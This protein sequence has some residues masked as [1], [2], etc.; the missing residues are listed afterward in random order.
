MADFIRSVV[1]DAAVLGAAC[2]LPGAASLADLWRVLIEERNTVRDAPVGRWPVERF[3]HPDQDRDGF[4]YTFAGGY[5][6]DPFAF[7]PA[8]FGISPREA[9]QVDPQQRV[10]LEVVREAFDDAGIPASELAGRNVGVYVGAST[11]DYQTGTSLDLAAMQSHFMTGNSL[12]ILANRISYVFNLKGPSFTVDTA[13]SSSLV[14][15]TQ[16]MT[17]LESGSIDM[18][19]VAGVNLL[20]SPAPFI[21]FSRARM[22]SPTGRCRPFSADGDGYVRAEGAVAIILQRLD[23]RGTNPLRCVIQAAGTNSDGRTDGIAMP[24]VEGQRILLDSIYRQSG[25]DPEQ[26]AFIEAHGTGTAVGDPAEAM[27]I[28]KALG[29]HR[30]EPLPI[31]SVKSNIGHL[32]SASGLASFAKV[33]L[34]LEHRVLPRSLF[35]E[36]LNPNIDFDGLNLSAS[37]STRE[38]GAGS[39]PL[40]AGIC[41]YGFGGTNAHVILREASEAERI[42]QTTSGRPARLLLVS[43]ASAG[44]LR[45]FA[46][47]IA[48]TIQSAPGGAGAVAATLA[49]RRERMAHRLA[50]PIADD[51]QVLDALARF[52]GGLS[53]AEDL[54]GGLAPSEAPPLVFVYSGNGS[55]FAGMGRGAYAANTAFRRHFD[56]LD[57]LFSPIAGWS[58]R[59]ALVAVD[60]EERLAATSVSQPLIFAIQSALTA[61]LRA[62]DFEPIAVLGHSVGEVAAAEACGALSLGDAVLLIHHRS[63][64]QEAVRGQG[65]M[66]VVAQ[67]EAGVL[68]LLEDPR[69]VRIAV[70]AINSPTSTTV[71]GPTDDLKMLATTCRRRRIATVSLDIDYPF[72]TAALDGVRDGMRH[73]L[74]VIKPVRGATPFIST[75][76]GEVIAGDRLD[77]DHWWRNIRHPVRFAEAVRCAARAGGR[78]FVEIGARPILTGAMT[79]TLREASLPGE[80]VYSL[81]R[82]DTATLDP[83]LQLAA[84]LVARGARGNDEQL[85]GEATATPLPAYPWQHQDF[86]LPCTAE[87]FNIYGRMANG[88][89]RHPLIGA[90]LAD[91]SPEWRT[92]LDAA[93]VPYLADHV[94]DGEIVVPGTALIEMALAAGRDL[95]GTGAL[96]LDEFDIFKALTLPGDA[97]REISLRYLEG[98]SQIEIW[99]RPRFASEEWLLHARGWIGK[100]RGT[101]GAA[102]S[103]PIP[104]G[105]RHATQAEIYAEARRAALDYGPYFRLA[106]DC[107]YDAVTTD[108]ALAPPAGGLGAFRDLHVLHPASFDASFHGLLVS[109]PQ[110]DGETKVHL[111]VRFRSVRVWKQG[112][113]IRHA[114][115]TLTFETERTKT[116]AMTMF[117]AAGEI[118]AEVE[119][120]VLAAM[121]LSRAGVTDRTFHTRL[122]PMPTGSSRV[123]CGAL[124]A[125]LPESRAEEPE[126]W[127]VARAFSVALAHETLS[128]LASPVLDPAKLIAEERVAE[129]AAPLLHCLIDLMVSHGH[130]VPE[131]SGWR[132][133]GKT[134]LP[135]SRALLASLISDYPEA[136]VEIRLAARALGAIPA[137]LAHGR[138]AQ[139]PRWLVEQAETEA[140]VHAGALAALSA[141]LDAALTQRGEGLRVLV[142]PP[143]NSGLMR[144]LR[145]LL[146]SNAI[147]LALAGDDRRAYDAWRD[148]MP[149]ETATEFIDLTASDTRAERRFDVLVAV[150]SAPLDADGAK[151]LDHARSWMLDGATILVAQPATDRH[152]DVLC[153]AWPAWFERSGIPGFA[154][155]PLPS[156]G[157][158]LSAL[159]R[160][161]FSNCLAHPA[162]DGMGHVLVATVRAEE[163]IPANFTSPMLFMGSDASPLG[164][165]LNDIRTIELVTADCDSLLMAL[166]ARPTGDVVDIV[167]AP[168]LAG[169]HDSERASDAVMRFR[170]L[171]ET[172]AGSG[173]PMRCWVL[174]RDV[175]GAAPD[176][177]DAAIWGFL[178]VATNEFAEVGLHLIDIAPGI[179]DTEAARRIVALQ[180]RDTEETEIRLLPDGDHGLRV[181]RGLPVPVPP[182]A[183]RTVLRFEQPGRLDRFQW[184]RDEQPAPGPGEVEVAVAATGLN[185]RDILVG[186]GMLDDDLL[187]AGLTGAAL[188]FECSGVVTAVGKGVDA[189]APGDRVAGFAKDAFASHL[190]APAWHFIKVPEGIA[191]DAAASIPVAFTTA[192]FALVERARLSAKD[193]VLIHGGAG[194]VGLAA[195]QIAKLTGATVI[196]TAGSPDKREIARLAGADAVFDSRSDRFVDDIR[197]AFGGVDVVLN[198]LAGPLMQASLD[199]V[200]P[201][202]RFI[203]LGKRDFL[204]NTHIGLRPF[205]RNLTYSGADLDELMAHEPESVRT[206]MATLTGHF[207]DGRLR[208]LPFRTYGAEEI[209]T[210]F[211]AMQAAE[212]IGKIIVTPPLQAGEPSGRVMFTARPGVHLVVGGTSGLGF[213]TARWLARKGATTLVLASRRGAV[214]EG[215]QVEVDAMRAEGVNLLIEPLDVTNSDAVTMLVER[216]VRDH[217]PLRGIIHA[218]MVLDDGMI[219]GLT[220]DRI[221]AVLRPKIDGVQALAGAVEGQPLD[222]FVVYSSATTM[223]GSPG[224][225]AY[226]AA[227][228]YLE[229]FMRARRAR[230][231]PALAIGWGAIADVGVIARNKDLSQRLRRTTGVIGIRSSDGLAHLGYLLALGNA[232]DPVQFYSN[233]APSTAAEKLT[234]LQSPAFRGL[235]LGRGGEANDEGGDLAT[236]I[237][238]KSEAQAMAMILDTLRREIA[239]IL[240]MPEHE[241][242][243]SRPMSGLGMDSLMALEMRMSIER[244][245]GVDM[246]L[247]GIGERSLSDLATRLLISLKVQKNGGHEENDQMALLARVHGK[248]G[249]ATGHVRALRADTVV[250]AG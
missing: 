232:V 146:R 144:L 133:A 175:W 210:A 33:L 106:L 38:L 27:A 41:N 211:R 10:L 194:G 181:R 61:A 45:D 247:V 120:A 22:L 135:G 19:V 200:K 165:A 90:R 196:A 182:D 17:A 77:A 190:V 105:L 177:V 118:V 28:G 64:H 57:A 209:E 152:F 11:V 161:G 46:P 20:L 40:T 82:K 140:L 94:L 103:P 149:L 83:V 124:L 107:R 128:G 76:G 188:G 48:E 202:G 179:S 170:S 123:A 14:A 141:A 222:Y 162:S 62:L 199:L 49:G 238:G 136:N 32:E 132:I 239:L 220:G 30:R 87:G 102:V 36:R 168:T 3:L 9:Q 167:V 85:F 244:A 217:G 84:R 160:A 99:S 227:N 172:A 214:E 117:D 47:C 154:I 155:G 74:G 12:S 4:A 226:V 243:I 68:D 126:A 191:L 183:R 145:P 195:I 7:D 201:F 13:C 16:A 213:A 130:A 56:A 54:T 104:D 89:P 109:R 158:S 26:L 108:A 50:I 219:G 237:E 131:G 39:D 164:E 198:S 206:M 6:D 59:E 63:K 70:A 189:L 67:G 60:L 208:P 184:V 234:L 44:A 212:H 116:V 143:W 112:A 86:S 192:W 58:L 72:H 178:R 78:L 2:R 204:D 88:A 171:L 97:M 92:L 242:E 52:T 37:S 111:P 100:A 153:G 15:L 8:P 163:V 216:L 95:F 150:A 81:D 241:I 25:I 159:Q 207:I 225:G 230:G 169:P 121:V 66:M 91:G 42:A 129:S 29:I 98:T 21:G 125:P 180:A 137:R 157:E 96:E 35:L 73:D 127:L 110:K 166:A 249:T 156:V 215:L 205:V 122:L 1:F 55:Q 197:A 174:T 139:V 187:G 185:F 151:A 236:T 93:I 142:I 5:I 250:S 248:A 231:L 34:A 113:I 203:E 224:Q 79:E 186:M 134:G 80:V 114:T 115:I 119:A 176:P 193:T 235:A 233:I 228:A 75:V 221:R 43:A 71:S 245:T 223:I 31:G 69:F 53:E 173:K 218:A 65:R 147:E 240:R 246:P 148:R 101:A 229:G 18:A 51:G 24:S 23:R 138:E